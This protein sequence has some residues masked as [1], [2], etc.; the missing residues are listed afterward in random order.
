MHR[1][2]SRRELSLHVNLTRVTRVDDTW[3]QRDRSS[4]T[5]FHEIGRRPVAGA[6]GCHLGGGCDN[7]TSGRPEGRNGRYVTG[8]Q[9]TNPPRPIYS[10][11]FNQ[12]RRKGSTPRCQR[13]RAHSSSGTKYCPI[14]CPSFPMLFEVYP[15]SGW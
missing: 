11:L 14:R 3:V 1:K 8:R 13:R 12:L 7:E 10:G 4:L 5:P 2:D 9:S 6:G 15:Q